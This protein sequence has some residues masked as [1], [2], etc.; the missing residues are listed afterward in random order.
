MAPL[1]NAADVL[2]RFDDAPANWDAA[3]DFADADGLMAQTLVVLRAVPDATLAAA[4]GAAKT[5][6]ARRAARLARG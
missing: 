5:L 1:T 4:F 2:A 6:A 3:Y